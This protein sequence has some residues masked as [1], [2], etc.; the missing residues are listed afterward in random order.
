[1]KK[2]LLLFISFSFLLFISCNKKSK[3]SD[4]YIEPNDTI[5]E[6]TKVEP[7]KTLAPEDIDF[8]KDIQYE[9][10]TLE[11]E[12]P[13]KDTVRQFQW[14]K[15][16]E[17]IAHIENE[18]NIDD[19]HEQRIGILS[20]YKNI[21]GEAPTIPNFVRDEYKMVADEYG[22]QRYQ[23]VPLY[24]VEDTTH[25]RYGRD[26]WIAKIVGSDSAEMIQ[27]HGV[28]FDGNY[29]IPKKYLIQWGTDLHFDKIIAVD[30][31]NQNISTLQKNDKTWQILSMNPST[32]GV[33]NPPYARET[34]LG[35]F[36]VQE[37]KEKMYYTKDGSSEIAGY[38]PYASRFSNGGYI[39]GVPSQ[40]PRTS[41]IEYSQSLGTTPRSHMCVRNASSHSKFIYD[42]AAVKES[43]VVVID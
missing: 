36:A 35:I 21:N 14:D 13:Y 37:K 6:T 28:S 43:I 12:Y 31:T 29:L 2:Y 34:P 41:I 11:D 38:A 8:Q 18:L 10:Y 5:P 17:K 9:K 32:T 22:V 25:V 24:T 33:H 23:S 20:N 1:M 30:V 39:H 27:I 26:G 15:I 42:W 19:P 4:N 3:Q 16:K 7:K 40:L